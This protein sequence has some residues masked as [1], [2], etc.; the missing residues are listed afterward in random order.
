MKI[1][2]LLICAVLASASARASE[3]RITGKDVALL[4]SIEK[5]DIVILRSLSLAIDGDLR[6]DISVT[7]G[8][9]DTAIALGQLINSKGYSTHTELQDCKDLCA[10]VWLSGKQ[11]TK[12]KNTR[13]NVDTGHYSN[14]PAGEQAKIAHY[15][16]DI[17]LELDEITALR[18][19]PFET[20]TQSD[21][22]G[23]VGRGGKP[24][25]QTKNANA[26]TGSADTGNGIQNSL[27]GYRGYTQNGRPHGQGAWTHGTGDTYK[28]SFRD[29][30]AHGKGV[31]ETIEGDKW[32]GEFIEGKPAK[33]S[34]LHSAEGRIHR[35][36]T[37]P[38][39]RQPAKADQLVPVSRNSLAAPFKSAGD[40][41]A[42]PTTNLAGVAVY[43]GPLKRGNP[44]GAGAV[45]YQDGSSFAGWFAKGMKNGPGILL[46]ADGSRVSGMWKNDIFQDES[47][48]KRLVK[49][50]VPTPEDTTTKPVPFEMVSMKALVSK[51]DRNAVRQLQQRLNDIYYD[52]GAADGQL[53]AR[54]APQSRPMPGTSDLWRTAGL[55]QI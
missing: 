17:G 7:S 33:H 51:P 48:P 31:I 4:G 5:D 10:L 54:P 41:A 53:A 1:F 49:V 39:V 43:S 38:V 21:A 13:I 26:E 52:V 15:L 50:S 25:I 27:A 45:T 2:A 46:R 18:S 34:V 8:D 6:F 32:E 47:A 23:N 20:G 3:I 9:F 42:G 14:R 11:R 29:G 19:A 55:R 24:A 40:T 35:G 36:Q 37:K 22:A 44:H 28:G 12:P 30:L 16:T